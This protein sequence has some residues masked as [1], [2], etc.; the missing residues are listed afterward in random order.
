MPPIKEI[1]PAAANQL[2]SSRQAILIDVREADEHARERISGGT[3]VPLSR[4]DP[5][6]VPQGK[7]ILYCRAGIRSM[8]AAQRLAAAGRTDLYNLS[9]GII[10]WQRAG[11]PIELGR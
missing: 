2:L 8:D 9:G 10:A 4:F 3:L 11:L 5:A 7:V 1:D 6:A